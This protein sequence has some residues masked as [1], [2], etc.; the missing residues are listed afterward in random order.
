MYGIPGGPDDKPL[1]ELMLGR[2]ST[3]QTRPVDPVGG[4][5]L[6]ALRAALDRAACSQAALS[7][8]ETLAVL[9][10]GL[11]RPR[12][13]KRDPDAVRAHAVRVA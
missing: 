5:V 10:F 1:V 6:D 2:R 12:G 8:P 3:C 9:E 4:A 11:R 13:R 7:H